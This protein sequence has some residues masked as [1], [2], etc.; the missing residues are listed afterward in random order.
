MPSGWAAQAAATA[1]AFVD[2]L[3]DAVT[4]GGPAGHHLAR[5]RRLRPGEIVTAADGSGWWRPYAVRASQGNRVVLEACGDAVCE[6]RLEPRLRVAFAVTKGAKPDVVVRKLT[7]LGVDGIVL[8]RS[9]RSVPRWDKGR[10]DTALERLRR[11]AREAA[12]Q[13][14][15]ALVPA[16]DGPSAVD[17]LRSHAGIVVADSR[18]QPA[19]RLPRAT[20]GEWLLVVGPEGGLTADEL[21]TLPGP[22]LALGPHVL[23]AETAAIAGAAVLTSRRA[24]PA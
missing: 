22:R 7:E 20:S 18:G 15:R 21:A 11:V 19:D 5:A 1:H 23:R 4:V 12:A 6:P 13:S 24:A 14:R 8:V 16:V 9:Q 2:R 17:E 10:V 3:D